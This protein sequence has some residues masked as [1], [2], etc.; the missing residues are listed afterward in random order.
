MRE[1]NQCLTQILNLFKVKLWEHHFVVLVFYIYMYV[2]VLQME[3]SCSNELQYYY[4]FL[5]RV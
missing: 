2:S 3:G 1:V 4:L 5:H